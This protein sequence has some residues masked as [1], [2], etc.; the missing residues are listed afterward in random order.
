MTRNPIA[1]NLRLD[2][3]D[4]SYA[5]FEQEGGLGKVHQLFGAE[6]PGVIE[7]LNRELAA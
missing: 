7:T 3:E 4:F 1:A 5:P 6:L 2:I